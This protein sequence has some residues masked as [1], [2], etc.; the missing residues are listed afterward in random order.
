MFRF[1]IAFLFILFCVIVC[2]YY[3][4]VHGTPVD[5]QRK[6]EW[7]NSPFQHVDPDD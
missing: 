7:D 3:V 4:W 1:K 6:L 5:V 2:V